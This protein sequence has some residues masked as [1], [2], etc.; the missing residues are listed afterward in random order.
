MAIAT[1]IRPSLQFFPVVMAFLLWLAYGRKTGIK[2]FAYIC[3]GFVLILSPWYIRNLVTLNKASNQSPMINFLHHGMYPD[4]RYKQME[5]SSRRPYQFDPRSEIIRTDLQSVT[6][7]I[8]KR[9]GEEPGRHLKWYL[10]GKPV[11]FWAWDMIQ[12]HGDMYVYYVSQSPFKTRPLF[13]WIQKLMKFF[14]G[15]LVLLAILGSLIVWIAPRLVGSDP[16][17][18]FMA[19]Y[20]S[21]LLI[22]F[23][24]LHMVGAPFPRYSVPLRPFQY[25]MALY[26]LNVILTM[27]ITNALSSKPGD[28]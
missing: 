11:S 18:L 12:G 5:K 10:L 23:T 19:R 3:L 8:L 21:A 7:E 2:L 24:A 4:F 25:A 27:K 26:A 9:F 6:A 22:Y 16:A 1:L 20:I 15:T 14:H 17:H 28:S 13:Q